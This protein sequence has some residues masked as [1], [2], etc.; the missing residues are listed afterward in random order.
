[1][2]VYKHMTTNEL[3]QIMCGCFRVFSGRNLLNE[4][5]LINELPSP[6]G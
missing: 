5:G 1:M 2:T 4:N 6:I 3:K